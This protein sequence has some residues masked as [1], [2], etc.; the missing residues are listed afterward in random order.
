[1]YIYNEKYKSLLNKQQVFEVEVNSL[2][3]EEEDRITYKTLDRVFYFLLS[4]D[5]KEYKYKIKIG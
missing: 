3:K 4:C 1:M 5:N 2:Y